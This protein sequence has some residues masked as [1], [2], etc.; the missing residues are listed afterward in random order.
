MKPRTAPRH[1]QAGML[2]HVVALLIAFVAGSAMYGFALGG[3]FNSLTNAYS[4]GNAMEL[5]F[6]SQRDTPLAANADGRAP[7]IMVGEVAGTLTEPARREQDEVFAR[8]LAALGFE[9]VRAHQLREPNSNFRLLAQRMDAARARCGCNI[10]TVDGFNTLDALTLMA[11]IRSPNDTVGGE[12]LQ[13]AVRQRA[14]R[15]AAIL[16]GRPAS[17]WDV[18]GIHPVPLNFA[19]HEPSVS[20][21]PFAVRVLALGGARPSDDQIVKEMIFGALRAAGV[22]VGDAGLAGLPFPGAT[23]DQDRI[24]DRQALNLT[25]FFI[26]ALGELHKSAAV[27]DARAW[28]T[29]IQGVEQWALIVLAWYLVLLL[30]WRGSR[31]R[32]QEKQLEALDKQISPTV[33]GDPSQAGDAFRQ[34]LHEL[35]RM[36]LPGLPGSANLVDRQR[37]SLPVFV[38]SAATKLMRSGDGKGAPRELRDLCEREA[39]GVML[40]R[41]VIAWGGR[42]LVGIGFIGT[43]RGIMAALAN[44]DSIVLA[45]DRI[46]Q[47][48]AIGDVASTLGLAFATTLIALILN[49]FLSLWLARQATAEMRFVARVERE[50]VPLLQPALREGSTTDAATTAAR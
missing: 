6:R 44:A 43:V 40:S 29:L 36:D 45:G 26:S 21:W 19:Q 14:D 50:M 27:R 37:K 35:L 9:N 15:L 10:F 3:A 47:A 1:L 28:V 48:V 32:L 46:E 39:Y 4:A 18:W 5:V 23:N 24:S 7:R 25:S 34:R 30:L 8:F 41:T 20:S 12:A 33:A 11:I 31:R 17:P 22:S 2:T 38:L 13:I 16:A 49:L 42:A